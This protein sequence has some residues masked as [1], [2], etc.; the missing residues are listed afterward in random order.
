MIYSSCCDYITEPKFKPMLVCFKALAIHHFPHPSLCSMPGTYPSEMPIYWLEVEPG[1]PCTCITFF[2]LTAT[3]DGIFYLKLGK[4]RSGEVDSLAQSH[5]A[6][7]QWSWEVCAHLLTFSKELSLA[8]EKDRFHKLGGKL[9]QWPG[10]LPQP[11]R[12]PPWRCVSKG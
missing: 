12:K 1:Y 7:F 2:S 9:P 5:R 8:P 4:L 10:P 11:G 3:G 6:S